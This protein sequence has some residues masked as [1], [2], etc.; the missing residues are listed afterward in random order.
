M[1]EI[2][3]ILKRAWHILWNYKILWIFGVLLAITA[4]GQGSSNGGAEGRVEL[5]GNYQFP[6]ISPDGNS[7]VQSVNTWFQQNIEPLVLHPEGYITTFVWIVI[8][9]LL[10]ILI[11]SAITTIIRYVSETAVIRMVDEYE[12]TGT[13]VGF[14][15]GWRLGWSRAAFRLWLID[16]LVV[17]IPVF[18]FILML[19]GIG[20]GTFN[21]VA[22]HNTFTQLGWATLV[23]SLAFGLFVLAFI[24]LMVFVNLLRMFFMR[25][26]CLEDQGVIE[27]IR[28]GWA[29]FR[30]N[31][32]NA[33]LMWLVLFGL[34]IGFVIAL[35]ITFIFMIPILIVTGVAGLVV[36]ILPAMFA[37]WIAS[38][39]TSGP[40]TWIIAVLVG[41]PF[42]AL[43]F[44]SPFLLIGGWAKIFASSVWTLTY[45]ELNALESLIPSASLPDAGM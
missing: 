11:M 30:R 43:V 34:G 22:G 13:K 15:A 37:Y 45:R 44:G 6:V 2:G 27:S 24:L 7:W 18:L 8:G 33:S 16:L 36:S 10:F 35:L 23:A 1:F 14:K 9:L 40:W 20:I 26:A 5:P 12:R 39:F 25:K 19:I 41:T 32:K 38:L 3:K 21:Y 42:F 31:W 17:G 28:T 29:M 4:S